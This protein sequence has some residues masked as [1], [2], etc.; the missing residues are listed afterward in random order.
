MGCE[1]R[2]IHSV[3][4]LPDLNIVRLTRPKILR[5][6][7]KWVPFLAQW[8]EEWP[9][10][11]MYGCPG[12]KAKHPE[13]GYDGEVGV[14]DAAPACW[15]G[16]IEVAHMKHESVPI[17]NVPFFSEVCVKLMPCRAVLCRAVPCCAVPCRAVPC[18]AVPCRAVPC[19]AMPCRAVLCCE[20]AKFR[21]LQSTCN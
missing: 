10:A 3:V 15:L 7:K 21:L 13:L 11:T 19:R 20:I 14:D 5:Q 4:K 8:K 1:V 9:E 2:V 18:R 17:F 12:L 6:L 16:E